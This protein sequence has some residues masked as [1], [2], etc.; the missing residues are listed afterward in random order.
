MD[1]Q[2]KKKFLRKLA[3]EFG[4]GIDRSNQVSFFKDGKKTP[5]TKINEDYTLI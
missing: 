5:V 1:S 4:N 3:E 2:K